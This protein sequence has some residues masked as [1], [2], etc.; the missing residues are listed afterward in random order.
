MAK[1]QL[2]KKSNQLVEGKYRFD[3]WEMRI[4]LKMLTLI[5]KDDGDFKEYRIYL[6]ELIKQFG[7]QN[8]K[9]SY[10]R[11]RAG[12]HKM[13]EKTISIVR[14]TTEGLKE[15]RTP[16]I[17]GV[18]SF[19]NSVDGT[20]VDISFH[21][22]MKPFLLQLRSQFLAYD[23]R[24]VL[25]ISSVHSIRIYELLAQYRAI[26]KRTI[27]V[28]ELK[29]MLGIENKY[30][31]WSH[32]RARIIDPAQV[33]LKE[34]CDIQFEYQV[35]KKGKR[36]DSI[37][38]FIKPNKAHKKRNKAQLALEIATG[39]EP[40]PRTEIK[41]IE[42]ERRQARISTYILTHPEDLKNALAQVVETQPQFARYL[43]E[44]LSD[45]ENYN[46]SFIQPLVDAFIWEKIGEA[47]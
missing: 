8:N 39:P 24:N 43:K 11:L 34:N 23:I 1:I 42:F 15:F 13:M 21:P 18:D 27:K 22:K 12:A 19:V 2:I 46:N 17:A 31:Q 5:H 10:N 6:T 9:D 45:M 40:D 38:F 30:K 28:L 7:I 25:H 32:L 47:A 20:Y 3:I 26:G 16:V 35:N 41:R 29:E 4:F 37:T 36:V 44:E 14:E 33:T